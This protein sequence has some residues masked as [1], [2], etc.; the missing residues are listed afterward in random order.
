MHHRLSRYIFSSLIFF[1]ACGPLRA[2][3]TAPKLYN[4]SANALTD[5]A[6]AVKQARAAK[7]YVL[8]MAGGNW[9]V[10]CLEFNRFMLSDP[11]VDSLLS[12]DYVLYHLNYS[13][14]NQN[15]AIL[16]KYGFPQRFGFPVFIV[17][18]ENGN[19]LHT[20]NSSYLEQGKSYNKRKVVE[21]LAS[22]NRSALDP[23]SYIKH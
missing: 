23:G 9:C 22:W 16:A 14:E 6:T 11:Q 18:D 10:W 8:L 5:I 7:K 19:R 15:G 1:A 20:Q 3:T 21:F 2:Q 4:P 12:A 13:Q 17:L